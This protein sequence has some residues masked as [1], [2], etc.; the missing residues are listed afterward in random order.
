MYFAGSYTDGSSVF[1]TVPPEG[2]NCN[3]AA[4]TDKEG[5]ESYERI[6]ERNK[7]VND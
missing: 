4:W 3:F 5:K 1:G 7:G 6:R 2:K